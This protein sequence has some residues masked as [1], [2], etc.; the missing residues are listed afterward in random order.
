[1]RKI[2]QFKSKRVIISAVLSVVSILL[3]YIISGSLIIGLFFAAAFLAAGIF[4]MRSFTVKWYYFLPWIMLASFVTLFLSQFM[5]NEILFTLPIK[6]IVLGLICCLV[7]MLVLFLI[8]MRPLFSAFLVAILIL[9]L[10]TV[11]AYVYELRGSELCPA[12]LLTIRTAMNVAD[13]YTYTLTSPILYSWIIFGVFAVFSFGLPKICKEKGLLSRAIVAGA[14]TV[15]CVVFIILNRGFPTQ[16][17]LHGGSYYNGFI[18]NFTKEISETFVHK[19][20]GY[21]TELITSIS[22]K[23]SNRDETIINEYPDIIV[24]MDEAYSD[25]SIIGSEI[26][27]NIPITPFIDSLKTNTTYGYTLTSAYGGGTP[28]S[29]YEFLSGNSLLFL[30]GVIYQQYLREP[31]Y[32]LVSYLKSIGYKSIA[33]HPYLSNGWRRD[34]VWPNLLFDKCMFIDEFP[35]K[36]LIRGSPKIKRIFIII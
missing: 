24:I 9:L 2:I 10:S 22:E 33:M 11:N 34:K 14:T 21:S 6:R 19:P 15:L 13:Q 4:S 7:P 1:M 23:Y 16:R 29:E 30:N 28:N 26:N 3:C 12:D 32:S 36:D 18:L 5:Q 27:T 17:F 20:S 25:L 8:S 35:Q 31:S